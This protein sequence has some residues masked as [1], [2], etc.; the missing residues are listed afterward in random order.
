MADV[1]TMQITVSVI[2]HAQASPVQGEVAR[3]AGGVVL[4]WYGG[5]DQGCRGDRY[6]GGGVLDAPPVNAGYVK[7]S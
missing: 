7:N 4:R 1:R 5:T 2:R 6:V 3:S